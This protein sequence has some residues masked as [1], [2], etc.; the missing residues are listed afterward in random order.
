M[1]GFRGQKFDF[2]G[3]DGAWYALVSN[4]PAMHLNMRVTAPVPSLPAITYITGISLRTMDTDGFP[5]SV[6]ISI[7][8]PHTINS[9]CPAGQTPC[10][11]DGSLGVVLDG[12]EALLAPESVE[13]APG[14][15]ITAVNIPGEC[16]SFGFEEYWERKKLE[17]AGG[18][19]ALS[20]T[21]SMGDWVLADPTVTNMVE[22][23]EYVGSAMEAD[24]GL[25][26]HQSEHSSF[27]IVTPTA[28]IR[29][30][31]GRLHQLAMRDPT[32]QFDLPDHLAWQMNLAIDRADLSSDARGILGETLVPTLDAGGEAIMNGMECIRGEQEDCKFAHFNVFLC[33]HKTW[34]IV[35]FHI[36]VTAVLPTG[37]L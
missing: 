8:D 36:P 35:L 24:G 3:E 11:A 15:Q 33:V 32:D 7:K 17:A 34:Q 37:R 22:C 5:H 23:I 9:S 14:V 6:V 30:S 19:R 25:F 31:H 10:L 26:A 21:V 2:T 20:E 16:R 13:L 18:G 28:T 1:V 29:L 4:I 27:K 12:E